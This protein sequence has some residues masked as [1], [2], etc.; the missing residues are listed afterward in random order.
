MS[1]LASVRPFTARVRPFA[2]LRQLLALLLALAALV[3]L[4]AGARAEVVAT[5]YAHELGSSFPHA[6]VLLKGTDEATGQAVDTNYGFTAVTISPAILFGRVKG[7]LDRADPAYIRSS[8]A[9]FRLTLDSAQYRALIAEVERWRTAPQPSYSLASA[10]CVHF[11]GALA[12]AVGLN[13]NPASRF[14]KKPRSYLEEVAALNRG[15]V[16]PLG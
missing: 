10:N 13:T 8:H 5:F 4:P 6:F 7:R 14:F 15:R 1:R 2:P 12:R 9:K 3:A 16:E 11:I